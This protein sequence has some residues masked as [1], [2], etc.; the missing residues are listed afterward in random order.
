MLILKI[1]DCYSFAIYELFTYI[2]RNKWQVHRSIPEFGTF[3]FIIIGASSSGCVIANRLSEISNWTVL[4]IEA[5]THRD[6]NLSDIPALYTVDSFSKFNWG[7]QTVPQ[8]HG[9]LGKKTQ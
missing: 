4:L 1:W 7:Y 8:K 2:C 6:E 3:D 9:C 5:G